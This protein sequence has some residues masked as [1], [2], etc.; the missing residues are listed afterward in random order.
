MLNPQANNRPFPIVY[1]LLNFKISF[2]ILYLIQSSPISINYILI[3]ISGEKR[4]A[5]NENVEIGSIFFYFKTSWFDKKMSSE[6]LYIPRRLSV[7]FKHYSG[8]FR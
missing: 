6:S 1:K 5:V 3:R 7:N 8:L 4:Y 2:Q